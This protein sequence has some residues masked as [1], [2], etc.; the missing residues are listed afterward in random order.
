MQID[1]CNDTDISVITKHI[2]DPRIT[3]VAC[4]PGMTHSVMCLRNKAK[5]EFSILVHAD[6]SEGTKYGMDKFIG[7]TSD[8]FDADGFEVCVQTEST[9]SMMSKAISGVN[10]VYEFILGHINPD[11]ELVLSFKHDFVVNHHKLIG[12]FPQPESIRLGTDHKPPA[13]SF[14]SRTYESI[15]KSV[16]HITDAPLKICGNIDSKLAVNMMAS[17]IPPVECVLSARQFIAFTKDKK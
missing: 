16:R 2:G 10:D 14:S 12:K 5:A 4:S 6:W 13:V 8:D 11:A 17:L 7:F 15:I 1:I 9:N 3:S